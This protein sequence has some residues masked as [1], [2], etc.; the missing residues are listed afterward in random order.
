MRTPKLAV[1]FARWLDVRFSVWCDAKIGGILK[2]AAEV[3]I[4]KSRDSAVRALPQSYSAALRGLATE[5]LSTQPAP[6][7][8]IA[9][10]PQTMKLAELNPTQ[11]QKSMRFA[12]DLVAAHRIAKGLTLD[13]QRVTA[14]RETIEERVVLALTEVDS[15]SMPE[16]WSWEHAAETIA[17]EIA[18]QIIRDQKNEPP[19]PAFESH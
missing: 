6:S 1:F 14:I 4:V 13:Q 3:T 19:D 18:L 9:G 5:R 12:L 10:R 7:R 16:T 15:G 11:L 2:G 17:V 8:L